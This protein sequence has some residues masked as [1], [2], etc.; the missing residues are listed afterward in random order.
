MFRD[1]H[2]SLAPK[3]KSEINKKRTHIHAAE[4]RIF[5]SFRFHWTVPVT[6]QWTRVQST[7]F[8]LNE[9]AINSLCRT[10]ARHVFGFIPRF[11]D[12]CA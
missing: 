8:D 2:S 3:N 4:P 10:A 12:I 11:Y 6:M 7:L 5:W 9:T 1:R